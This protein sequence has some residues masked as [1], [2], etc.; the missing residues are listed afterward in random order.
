MICTPVNCGEKYAGARN[1][2]NFATNLCEP[3]PICNSPDVLNEQENI[4]VVKQQAQD[5]ETQSPSPVRSP[6]SS[7]ATSKP[8]NYPNDVPSGDIDCGEHG[9][10]VEGGTTC[11]CD[12]GWVS[13]P[14][15]DLFSFKWCAVPYKPPVYV[16]SICCVPHQVPL[17]AQQGGNQTAGG[18]Q[19]TGAPSG[20]LGYVM[21]PIFIGITLIVALGIVL[22]CISC[23][24]FRYRHKLSHCLPSQSTH[25][26]EATINSRQGMN[27]YISEYPAR[28]HPHAFR[29]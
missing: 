10:S 27:P 22:V 11:R 9:E 17:N 20:I 3:V 4:C 13:D 1:F 15:Q 24:A 29:Q 23:I 21:S 7:V 5:S 19:P 12:A 8:P 14:N 2:F 28:I 18:D 6:D 16:V 26:K 25:H